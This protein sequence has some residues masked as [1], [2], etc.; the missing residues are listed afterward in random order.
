MS[1]CPILSL[2]NTQEGLLLSIED[3][4]I[5]LKGKKGCERIVRDLNIKLYKDTVTGLAAL[6][7]SAL[8]ICLISR[9]K[10]LCQ[11]ADVISVLFSRI[12]CLP[13]IR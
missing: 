10:S 4:N 8:R 11:S 7:D 6:S 9:R 2:M 12:R 3:L 13:L 5:S 1:H